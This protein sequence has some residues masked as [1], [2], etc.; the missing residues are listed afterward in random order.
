MLW[1]WEPQE[2]SIFEPTVAEDHSRHDHLKLGFKSDCHEIP[3]TVC[4]NVLKLSFIVCKVELA[5]YREGRS[6]ALD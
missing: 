4:S 5:C 1:G 2:T 3:W 6:N